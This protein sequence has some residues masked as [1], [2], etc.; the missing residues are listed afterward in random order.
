MRVAPDSR[1]ARASRDH[2][3]L[4]ARL[5]LGD[6]DALGRQRVEERLRLRRKEIERIGH[7]QPRLPERSE[8]ARDEIG[9]ASRIHFARRAPAVG[10]RPILEGLHVFV[11]RGSPP[12]EVDPP[13][14]HQAPGVRA[15][16]CR[17]LD[18]EQLPRRGADRLGPQELLLRAREE[19]REIGRAR[20]S[21]R[22]VQR[23]LVHPLHERAHGKDV[24]RL[25][26]RP[27]AGELERIELGDERLREPR[28]RRDDGDPRRMALGQPRE[29]LLFGKHPCGDY[30]GKAC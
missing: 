29:K 4:G 6:L 19:E 26:G 8:M 11:C 7:E 27:V 18:R 28:V 9:Q 21:W 12:G 16:G 3:I 2:G 10:G 24:R 25:P 5:A 30:P 15:L 1:R 20:L 17:A 14:V 23:V 13:G 22:G